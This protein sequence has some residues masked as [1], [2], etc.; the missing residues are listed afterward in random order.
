MELDKKNMRKIMLLIL[1][2]ALIYVGLQHMEVLIGLLGTGLHLLFPFIL[3]AAIAFI[4]NVPMHFLEE[5]IFGTLKEK[6]NSKFR[7]LVR[8]ASL[9]LSLILVVGIVMLVIL[10]VVPDLATTAVSLGRNIERSIPKIQ[11]WA[12]ETFH[13]NTQIVEWVRS[14]EVNWEQMFQSVMDMLRNSL[15][16]VLSSTV[17]VTMG[18]FSAI[19]NLCIGFVFACYLLLQKERLGRQVRK[20]LQAFMPAKRVARVIYICS[21]SYRTF[22]NFIT[23]QCIEAVILGTMFFIVMS[24][25]QFPYALLVG[26]LIAFTA[27]I[28]IFGAFIGCIVGALLILMVNPMQALMFVIMFLILQQI[29]G[30]L[31]YPHV[32]GNSVGLPSIWVLVAVTLG[33]NL[34]GVAG[35]LIFIPLMSVAYALFREWVYR[36]LAKKARNG[37]TM[38]E[39]VQ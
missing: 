6:E 28:P 20:V 31:I 12:I 18:I 8:P 21:L 25:F 30:N 13:N 19:A 35:M 34:M 2:A 23:G 39:P 36:R 11:A 10:V 22:S 29:E 24:I 9:I 4:L 15:S 5:K 33:G 17:S 14:I 7:K 38:N 37:K 27:L 16:N 32:V 26:V 1:F 3:G